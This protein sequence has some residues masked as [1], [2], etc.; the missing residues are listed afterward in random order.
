LGTTFLLRF[1]VDPGSDTER[2][3]HRGFCACQ[4]IQPIATRKWPVNSVRALT[5]IGIARKKAKETERLSS[6]RRKT[7]RRL[8][9]FLLWAA[10]AQPIHQTTDSLNDS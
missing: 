9:E 5:L 2:K 8:A 1:F 4:K 6:A 10:S 3:A 7:R